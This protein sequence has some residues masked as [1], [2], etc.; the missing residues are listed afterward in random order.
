M[1]IKLLPGMDEGEFRSDLKNFVDIATIEDAPT[2]DVDRRRQVKC[3]M[4]KG[5]QSNQSRFSMA[6]ALFPTGMKLADAVEQEW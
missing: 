1:F 4:V 6:L 5:S 3:D 2:E